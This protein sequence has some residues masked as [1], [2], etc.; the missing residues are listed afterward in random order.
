LKK[1]TQKQGRDNDTGCLAQTT[2]E[3]VAVKKTLQLG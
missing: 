2:K 1:E 3:V